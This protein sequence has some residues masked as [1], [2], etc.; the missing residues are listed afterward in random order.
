MVKPMKKLDK[1]QQR[2][3]EKDLIEDT[4]VLDPKSAEEY[5]QKLKPLAIIVVVISAFLYTYFWY[6]GEVNK[7][8]E[9]HLGIA[10]VDIRINNI[11]KAESK[12][13]YIISEYSGSVAAD[14]A[15][16]FLAD[17]YLQKGM[18]ESAREYFSNYSGDDVLLKSASYAGIALCYEKEKKYVEAAKHYEKAVSV[19]GETGSR[20]ANYLFAAGVNYELANDKESAKNVYERINT[21]YKTFSKIGIVEMKLV[22]L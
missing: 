12:L 8:A 21:E 19:V 22:N 11:D 1:R 14:K 10:M 17:I 9:D 3:P 4:T 5:V 16:Y 6:Q 13:N 15:G 18:Y 2:A 20:N 7:E